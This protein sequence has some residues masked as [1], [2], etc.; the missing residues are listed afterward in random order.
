[1]EFL[2]A[3]GRVERS[4]ELKLRQLAKHDFGSRADVGCALAV[5]TDDGAVTSAQTTM[6]MMCAVSAY[7]PNQ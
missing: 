6:K 2:V 3:S 1:L 7:G 5:T 4:G